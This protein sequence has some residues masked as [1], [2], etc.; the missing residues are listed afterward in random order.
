[1]ITEYSSALNWAGWYITESEESSAQNGT[2]MKRQTRHWVTYVSRGHFY[3]AWFMLALKVLYGYHRVNFQSRF[4]IAIGVFCARCGR[5]PFR[6]V[7]FNNYRGLMT[8]KVLIWNS[9][10]VF[11]FSSKRAAVRVLE[12]RS[13]RPPLRVWIKASQ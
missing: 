4:L 8:S 11:H 12:P 9:Y 10:R 3:T 2:M 5:G 13:Y 7:K 6:I 1:M